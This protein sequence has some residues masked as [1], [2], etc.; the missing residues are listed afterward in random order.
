MC[1]VCESKGTEDKINCFGCKK[2]GKPA[3][4]KD[5]G[6]YCYAEVMTAEFHRVTGQTIREQ[7]K[8]D[9]SDI[10]TILVMP[11]YCD[12]DSKEVADD[13]YHWQDA[14]MIGW[15]TNYGPESCFVNDLRE[16]RMDAMRKEYQKA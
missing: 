7:M 9:D 10:V 13:R 15:N 2:W 3:C 8:L 12:R 14:Y 11:C 4:R 16:M 6:K 1:D 5:V